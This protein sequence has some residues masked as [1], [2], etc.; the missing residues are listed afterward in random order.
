MHGFLGF[1]GTMILLLTMVSHAHADTGRED[2][3]GLRARVV[4]EA[5][6]ING[7]TV[8]V[9][10]LVVVIYGT[11]ERHSVSGEWAKLDTVK[12]YIKAVNQRR[13]TVG[14][15]PDGWSK[16]IALDRIQTLSLEGSSSPESANQGSMQA[17]EEVETAADRTDHTKE[18]DNGRERIQTQVDSS[19][20]ASG[21]KAM[22]V[23]TSVRMTKGKDKDTGKRIALKLG[24]GA[25]LGSLPSLMLAFTVAGSC[26]GE[27]FCIEG[28][29]ALA[30]LSV[31]PVGVAIGVSRFDPYDRFIYSLTGSLLGVLAGLA[32][33]SLPLAFV[34]S[35]VLAT[36]M[37]EQSR[38]PSEIRRVAVSLVPT[39][40]GYL[41][42]IATLRF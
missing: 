18:L 21:L 32:Q 22:P 38:K 14:L 39:P 15:E 35:P 12:G 2:A 19:R 6:E 29:L 31:Y 16:W 24:H 36:L 10:A 20:A 8:E 1:L 25:I 17:D 7:R 23:R 28:S 27:N 40:K 34:S 37:S 26:G 13:L 5:G 11:G 9:G 3:E 33:G 41:S 4:L 42:A 30:G